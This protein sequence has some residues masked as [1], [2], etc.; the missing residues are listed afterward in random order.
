MKEFLA[1]SESIKKSASEDD[2]A[3]IVPAS[4]TATPVFPSVG[5]RMVETGGAACP[6]L[7]FY[8]MTVLL[9]D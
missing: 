7:I 3:T 9:I 6:E 1:K 4:V 2:T 5:W 8:T